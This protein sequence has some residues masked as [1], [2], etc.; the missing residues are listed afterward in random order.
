MAMLVLMP[1]A[2]SDPLLRIY[3]LGSSIDA[4]VMQGI[5]QMA[6]QGDVLT[7]A[8]VLFCVVGRAGH[9]GRGYCLP[10]LWQ[11]SRDEPSPGAAD[12]G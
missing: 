12:A 1:V 9:A 4:N 10:L 3:L 7:A 2:F 8:V 5:W 6:S 11:H